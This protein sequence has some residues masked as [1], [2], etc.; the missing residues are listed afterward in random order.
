MVDFWSEAIALGIDGLI[1]GICC[2]VY[3]RNKN[4][5]RAVEQAPVY[6]VSSKLEDILDQ[7]ADKKFPYVVVRGKVK[8]IGPPIRSQNSPEV[9]G[10]VQK[11]SLKEHLTARNS[12]GFWSDREQTIQENYKCTPFELESIST[13]DWGSVE[14]VEPLE[15]NILDLDTIVDR[16]EPTNNT[17]IKD[18]A[19]FFVGVHQRGLENKEEM[20][21]VGT[22]LTG[23]GELGRLGA[24]SRLSL[25]P[26]RDGRPY[27]LTTM[28]VTSLVRSLDDQMRTYRVLMVVFGVAGAVILSLL[29]RRWWRERAKHRSEAAQR[30]ER[31]RGARSTEGLTESQLCV[32]CCANPRETILVPCGHVCICEDCSESIV[33]A[34]PVCRT[35]IESKMHAYIV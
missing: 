23:I 32:V 12:A 14:V 4:A 13:A 34:C 19:S 7:Q 31:R 27:Y 1:F 28:P 22:I 18:L 5:L 9:Y 33:D 6:D 10:V 3:L 11:V 26:P 17:F 24:D 8:A 30:K 16:F 29:L 21:Q 15:A 2:K 25:M 20:L 35:A